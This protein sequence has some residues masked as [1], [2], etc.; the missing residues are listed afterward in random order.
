MGHLRHFGFLL[1]LSLTFDIGANGPMNGRAVYGECSK[2]HRSKIDN[3]RYGVNE[4]ICRDC[5]GDTVRVSTWRTRPQARTVESA[6]PVEEVA[7]KDYQRVPIDDRWDH[8]F[9]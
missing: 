6:H 2:C 1:P 4:L 7:E 9:R 5:L 8:W 3:F